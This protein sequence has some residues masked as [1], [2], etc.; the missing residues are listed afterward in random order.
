MRVNVTTEIAAPIDRVWRALTVIDQV[1][2]WDGVVAH[3]V[4][5]DY[6]APGQHARWRSAFGPLQLMLHDRIVD[7]DENRRFRSLIDIAFI[8]VDEEYL[9]SSNEPG[10]TT[11][12]TNDQVH[13]RIPGLGWLAVLLTR[14]NVHDSMSRL[15]A[16]CELVPP[17]P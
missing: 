15:K 9:L 4:P 6:P 16:Y 1:R 13:S 10:V 11:L 5:E 3:D 14:A 12:V 8:R 17:S 2:A 7:V